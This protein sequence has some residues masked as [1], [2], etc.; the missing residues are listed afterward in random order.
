MS[1]ADGTQTLST[2]VSRRSWSPSEAESNYSGEA[3]R[4]VSA[5]LAS[6]INPAA[7]SCAV[8]HGLDVQKLGCQ[9]AG[10]PAD[11][12]RATTSTLMPTLCKRRKH[13]VHTETARAPQERVRKK[14]FAQCSR[15]G[16]RL[17]HAFAPMIIATRGARHARPRR[18]GT[19]SEQRPEITPNVC[20]ELPS[21][22][23]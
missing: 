23:K 13:W 5:P 22:Q 2:A 17:Q 19:L 4:A 7:G 3:G 12:A 20:N 11:T 6:P 18:R 16:N 21:R 15:F 10:R 1:R 9:L 8:P 14:D